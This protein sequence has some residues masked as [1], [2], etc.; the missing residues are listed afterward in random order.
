[1]TIKQCDTDRGFQILDLQ[2]QARLR[3]V[4]VVGCAVDTAAFI[5]SNE[6]ANLLEIHEADLIVE[7]R[8]AYTK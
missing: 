1:M 6:G 7:T 3:D 4:E 8:K 5:D 2:A